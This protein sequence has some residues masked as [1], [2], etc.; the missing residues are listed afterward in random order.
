M[1]LNSRN[2]SMWSKNCWSYARTLILFKKSIHSWKTLY[3]ILRDLDYPGGQTE[4]KFCNLLKSEKIPKSF[5]SHTGNIK[6][7]IIKIFF[8]YH[9]ALKIYGAPKLC[10]EITVSNPPVVSF[11]SKISK[12]VKSWNN[13]NSHLLHIGK[14]K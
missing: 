6:K 11:L 14:K 9:D 3:T 10:I 12:F 1:E 2:L 4:G 5:L 13:L 7:S 8:G